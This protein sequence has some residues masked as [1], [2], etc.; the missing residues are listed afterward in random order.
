MQG[1]LLDLVERAFEAHVSGHAVAVK[2]LRKHS[3]ALQPTLALILELDCQLRTAALSKCPPR[4]HHAAKKC[5]AF[6][7]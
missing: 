6:C 7:S 3:Q 5:V 2:A 4:P 1:R